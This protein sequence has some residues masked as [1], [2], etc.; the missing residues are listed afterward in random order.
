L[1]GEFAEAEKSYRKAS[2]AG[3]PP[4][5]GLALLRL[6]QG[7]F[8]VAA[9]ILRR[10]LDET[11]EPSV[12]FRVLPAH[13]EAMIASGDVVSARTGADEL[14]RI[15]ESLDTPYPRAVAGSALGAVLLA[16][17]D[18]RSALRTLRVAAS[19]W[20]ELDAPYEAARVQVL[21]GLAC[22]ALSDPETFAMELDGAA[23]SSHS[24]GPSRTSSGSMC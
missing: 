2:E 4:E 3:H 9:G 8:D 11:L 22:R 17:G 14:D 24:W 13:V 5:P 12:R 16:E 6:A 23:R 7:R 18:P 1:R 15:A 20:R 19:A 10:A 21:I